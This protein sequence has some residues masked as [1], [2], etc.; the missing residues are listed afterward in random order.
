MPG[1][2]IGGDHDLVLT[3]IKLK[4]KNKSFTKSPR[5]LF[6]LQKLK[7]P[8]IADFFQA[9]VGGQFAALCVLYS[10]VDTL[11][12][13][14]KEVLLSAAEEVLERQRKKSQF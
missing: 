9:K 6:D 12:N 11:A 3:T 2:D 13:S 10:D 8:K 1:A 5:I 4:L 7:D 14:L